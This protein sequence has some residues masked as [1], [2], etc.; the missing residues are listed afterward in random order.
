MIVVVVLVAEEAVVGGVKML[1]NCVT[2]THLHNDLLLRSID[3]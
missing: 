3:Y 1:L 2:L